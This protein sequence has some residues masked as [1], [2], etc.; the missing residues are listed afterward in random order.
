MIAATNE[1]INAL[2]DSN[3][4]VLLD[5]YAPWCGPCKVV[6]PMLESMESEMSHVKFAKVDVDSEK[7]IAERYGIMSVPTI[8]ILRNGKEIGR[9]SGINGINPLIAKLREGTL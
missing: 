1:N 2:L 9:G 7:G 3:E 8:V 6:M 4:T 5:F